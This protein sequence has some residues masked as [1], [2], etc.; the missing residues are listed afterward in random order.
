MI[1]KHI[2]H[3]TKEDIDALVANGVTEGRAIEYK[4]ELPG[5]KDDERREFYADVSSLANAGGG[6]LVLGIEEERDAQGKPTGVPKAA[7]GV[8]TANA[9]G[10]IL[11]LENGIRTGIAPRIYSVRT[12]AIDG[13]PRGPVIV[14]RIPQSFNAPHMVTYK[15]SSR[16]YGRSSA[17]KHPPRRDRAACRLRH[18]RRIARPTTRLSR[19]SPKPHPGGRHTRVA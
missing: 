11:S 5:G 19:R 14:I 8:P 3:I 13:F 10:D 4:E 2:N 12:R 17:G 1:T 6:D 18:L 16:F 15:T 7:H 9:T